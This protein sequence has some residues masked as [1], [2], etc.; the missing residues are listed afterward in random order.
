MLIIKVLK[1][2]VDPSFTDEQCEMRF[3]KSK[4][5][6]KH[7]YGPNSKTSNTTTSS[8]NSNSE[9][10]TATASPLMME[11]L[12]LKKEPIQ[13]FSAVLKRHKAP[14]F[15]VGGRGLTKQ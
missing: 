1:Q 15:W 11:P 14:S 9:D 10:K 3:G 13:I 2:C 4:L 8:S 6:R 12:E 5:A 7:G